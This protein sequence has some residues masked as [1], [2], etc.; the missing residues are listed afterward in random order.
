[1]PSRRCDFSPMPP[2]RLEWQAGEDADTAL[3]EL[4]QNCDWGCKRDAHGKPEH[5]KGGK[6]HAAVTRDGIPV[7]VVYTSAYA[8][9]RRCPSISCTAYSSLQWSRRC[10]SSA[11]PFRP[12]MGTE[13]LTTGMVAGF[14]T[15]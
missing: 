11:D 7:A 8:R 1:M 13:P 14:A 6:V 9:R 2:S 4:P 5:W 15:S 12:E 3:A 10:A